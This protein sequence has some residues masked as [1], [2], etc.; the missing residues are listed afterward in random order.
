MPLPSRATTA[1]IVCTVGLAFAAACG[2]PTHPPFSSD[3]PDAADDTGGLVPVDAAGSDGCG[4]VQLVGKQAGNVLVVFDQSNSMNGAYTAGDAGV[5]HPKYQVARDALLAAI[6]PL[7]ATLDVGAIF[8]PTVATGNECSLVDPI[9]TAPQIPMSSEPSFAK[10]WSAHFA[11]PFKTILGT[12]LA[13]ALQRADAAYVEPSPLVGQRV[14]VVLT[15]GAPTCDNVTA[16]ILAP[17]KSLAARGIKTYVVG[18]PGSTAQ[19]KLLDEIAAAGGTG[20][21]LSPADPAALETQL[22]SIAGASIDRCTFT[23]A[24]PPPDPKQVH[25]VVTDAT[26]PSAYE[27]PQGSDWTLSDDGTTATLA[28]P[29]CDRAKAN[30]YGSMQFVFGCVSLF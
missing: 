19:S 17:V 3:T 10:A 21:Y 11:A 14:V 8:F 28:G 20:N 15:D 2:G 5:S 25:L 12:P 22:A 27:I 24:P 4:S 6:G 9:S 18:L 7:S 30:A 29:L 26:H 23:F 13:V 16:D 1:Q